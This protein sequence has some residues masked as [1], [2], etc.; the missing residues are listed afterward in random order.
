MTSLAAENV[1]LKKQLMVLKRQHKRY[2]PPLGTSDR[3]ILGW[4]TAW[5]KKK[6]LAK[7]A[8]IAKPSTLLKFH[9]ALVKCKYQLLF[10][11]IHP[12]KARTERT[13]EG[14]HSACFSHE[15]T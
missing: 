14:N 15:T 13:L 12:Q 4:L 5:I 3:I 10:S 1:I 7:I 2:P 9:Q 8:I 11:N 6:R